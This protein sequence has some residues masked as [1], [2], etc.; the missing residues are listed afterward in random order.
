[1]GIKNK[2]KGLFDI[3]KYTCGH[4]FFLN[5]LF[6]EFGDFFCQNSALQFRHVRNFKQAWDLSGEAVLH[7]FHLKHSSQCLA[8]LLMKV[9]QGV[10][11]VGEVVVR[12]G[13]C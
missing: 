1:M 6:F 11:G 12:V 13:L 5:H 2:N 9:V 10:V 7:G 8:V 3:R 4:M